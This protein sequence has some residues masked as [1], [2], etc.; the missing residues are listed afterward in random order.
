MRGLCDPSVK[1]L[2]HFTLVEGFE[3]GIEDFAFGKDNSTLGYVRV[4]EIDYPED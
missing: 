4:Y 2:E 3:G 1:K